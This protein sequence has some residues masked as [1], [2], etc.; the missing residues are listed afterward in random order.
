MLILGLVLMLLCALVVVGTIM[1]GGESATLEIFGQSIGT[2]AA[3]LF[4]AGAATMLL[5]L[6]GAWM[7]SAAMGRAR[8]K[9]SERKQKKREQRDSVQRLEEE[10]A[11]LREENE[12]LAQELSSTERQRQAAGAGSSTG[13]DQSLTGATHPNDSIG[14]PDESP[15]AGQ[16]D[17][18]DL[19]RDDRVVD[20]RSDYASQD[21]SG[22]RRVN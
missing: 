13:S 7:A 10:R 9:R 6:L 5:F 8:R 14:G 17:H 18:D 3:G 2:T 12:R 15:A 22:S 19:G 16:S 1:D 11:K 21:N 20:A 4:L